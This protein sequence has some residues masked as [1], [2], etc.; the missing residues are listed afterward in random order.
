M[1]MVQKEARY[2]QWT[3]NVH[4][5]PQLSLLHGYLMPHADTSCLLTAP[6]GLLG[7]EQALI[8]ASFPGTRAGLC[9]AHTW[10]E[11]CLAGCSGFVATHHVRQQD[12]FLLDICGI[13]QRVM[14]RSRLEGPPGSHRASLLFRVSVPPTT[15]YRS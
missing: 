1:L 11:E 12:E 10:M 4:C 8:S 6:S 3:L 14:G 15:Q 13:R 2:P 9:R 7:A 5:C